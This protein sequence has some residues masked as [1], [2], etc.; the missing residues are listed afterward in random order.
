[1]DPRIWR[2]EK[3]DG[4][5]N[6]SWVVKRGE[7]ARTQLCVVVLWFPVPEPSG[8]GLGFSRTL[9]CCSK[10]MMSSKLQ[11]CAGL[12]FS[13][14]AME[15]VSVLK[16]GSVLAISPDVPLA[17]SEVFPQETVSANTLSFAQSRGSPGMF[18]T[19]EW[20]NCR[21]RKEEGEKKSVFNAKVCGGSIPVV[22][23]YNAYPGHVAQKLQSMVPVILE[24]AKLAEPHPTAVLQHQKANFHDFKLA[25]VMPDPV[26]RPPLS[27][28]CALSVAC[29]SNSSKGSPA[30]SAF[31]AYSSPERLKI[32]GIGGGAKP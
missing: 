25:Q 7:G 17:T 9:A 31:R 2:K 8:L 4:N 3:R 15:R 22:W 18:R 27:P 14:E 1:M 19:E 28:V 21:Q 16:L 29:A 6:V 26:S 23:L 20:N 13:C 32:Q 24:F 10:K 5:K 12:I 11:I 30:L